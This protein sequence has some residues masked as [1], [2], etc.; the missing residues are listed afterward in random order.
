[1]EFYDFPYIGKALIPTDEVIFLR[2]VAQ[3]PT[4]HASGWSLQ[5][6][7]SANDCYIAI[8]HGPVEIVDLSSYKMVMVIFHGKLWTF[9][10][11]FDGVIMVIYWN[12]FGLYWICLWDFYG[13]QWELRLLIIQSENVE[14][15]WISMGQVVSL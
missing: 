6:K 15:V 8:E 2:G 7:P 4:R 3:P 12:F 13:I 1:M 5:K 14:H 10:R 11:G 9:T